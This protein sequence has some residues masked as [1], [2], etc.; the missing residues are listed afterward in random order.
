MERRVA[1]MQWHYALTSFHCSLT[2]TH[3]QLSELFYSFWT[4]SKKKTTELII[5]KLKTHIVYEL[6]G[7]MLNK[8]FFLLHINQHSWMLSPATMELGFCQLSFV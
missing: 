4:F 7:I 6:K 5:I 1:D 2:Y 8:S 3:A